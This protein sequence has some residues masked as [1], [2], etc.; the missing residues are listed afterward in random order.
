MLHDTAG[1]RRRGADVQ[2]G[3]ATLHL[4][5]ED[6]GILIQGLAT[7]R[8]NVRGHMHTTNMNK[9]QLP[10]PDP[11][12]PTMTAADLNVERVD[13]VASR[14]RYFSSPPTMVQ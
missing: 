7:S 5:E 9:S 2:L 11:K 13:P 12:P 10:L 14:P 4:K 8:R 3:R 1:L 6:V